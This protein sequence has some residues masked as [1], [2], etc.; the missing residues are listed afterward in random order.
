MYSTLSSGD[1]SLRTQLLASQVAL[2][3][4]GYATVSSVQTVL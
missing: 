2:T 4:T 3:S 1:L